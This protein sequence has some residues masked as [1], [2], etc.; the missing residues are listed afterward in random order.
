MLS[1][2]IKGR[3]CRPITAI[4]V[5]DFSNTEPGLCGQFVLRLRLHKILKLGRRAK[6]ITELKKTFGP[7]IGQLVELLRGEFLS[8]NPP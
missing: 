1:K 5:G 3:F 4:E 2:F 7:Q 8:V 6:P